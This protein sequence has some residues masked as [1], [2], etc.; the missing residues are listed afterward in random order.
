MKGIGRQLARS[1]WLACAIALAVGCGGGGGGG[2]SG[3]SGGGSSGGSSSSSSGAG[4]STIIVG[5]TVSG[6]QGTGLTLAD[7]G[8]DSLPIAVNGSFTFPTPVATG[9]SYS[10][11]VLVQPT[12]PAQSCSVADGAGIA[13]TS[14]VTTVVVTCAAT[15][16]NGM[17]T[18][19]QLGATDVAWDSHASQLV[20]AIGASATASANTIAVVNPATGALSKTVPTGANPT[21]VR[22]SDDGQFL[23]VGL[24]NESNIQRFASPAL[25]LDL[26]IPVGGDISLGPLHAAEIQ[27]APGAAHTIAVA[28]YRTNIEPPDSDVAVFDDAVARTGVGS[29]DLLQWGADATTLYSLT[30]EVDPS[31][32]SSYSVGPGG[33][34]RTGGGTSVFPSAYD[35]K[36]ASGHLFAGDGIVLDPATMN[37]TG[38]L[39]SSGPVVVDLAHNLIFLLHFDPIQNY[40]TLWAFDATNY[41]PVGLLPLPDAEFA[42][43]LNNVPQHMVRWGTDGLAY[44]NNGGALV[45]VNHVFSL[46]VPNFGGSGALLGASTGSTSYKIYDLPANDLAWSPQ[47]SLI[48][49]SLPSFASGRGNT[50][51]SFD[52]T[53]GTFGAGVF[54]GS[55]PGRISLSDDGTYLYTGLFGATSVV[56]LALPSLAA[57][58]QIALSTPQSGPLYPDNLWVAPAQPQT[59]AVLENGGRLTVYDSTTPRATSV[60]AFIDGAQWGADASTLYT[61][62]G[63]DTGFSVS[64]AN[65]TAGGVGPL[66]N[67]FSSFYELGLIGRSVHY[68]GGLL[69]ADDGSVMDPVSAT[70][71]AGFTGVVNGV[72][73]PDLALG[74]GFF[75]TG[76]PSVP[77]III[78]SVD[79][80]HG[81]TVSTF[82]LPDVTGL[83]LRVVRWGADGLAFLTDSG[84]FVVVHGAFVTTPAPANPCGAAVGTSLT[85]AGPTD[86]TFVSHIVSAPI[87]DVVVPATNGPLYVSIGGSTG[88]NV[89]CVASVDPTT[90]ALGA[91]AF[92]GSRPAV[93]AASDDA[94]KLY[95][96]LDAAETIQRFALPALSADATI[97][98]NFTAPFAQNQPQAG[99][100]EV[101]PGAPA[102]IA[103]AVKAATF[104]PSSLGLAIVDGTTP[105]GQTFDSFDQLKTNTLIWAGSGG[106]L[107]GTSF[108]GSP[109]LATFS[110]TSSGLTLASDLQNVW[111]PGG[112]SHLAGGLFYGDGGTVFDPVA[113]VVVG[114]FVPNGGSF[115][116]TVMTV[117]VALGRAYFAYI[118]PISSTLRVQVFDLTHFTLLRTAN[119]GPAAGRTTRIV[120]WGTDGLAI[121]TT[122]TPIYFATNS[123]PLALIQGTFVTS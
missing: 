40:S 120:R 20:I 123:G 24:Q 60:T 11:T 6:L 54:V 69:Y 34:A 114:T 49:V 37:V 92:A 122:N 46:P 85:T 93:L 23:Y 41:T 27:V 84:E 77:G 107:Y 115:V 18:A 71:K 59:F 12:N 83:P 74:L 2:G 110:V 25:T 101:A 99:D 113:G 47:R 39:V 65:V 1:L 86:P 33:L 72:M 112:R 70:V 7:N 91:G 97:P 108:E 116:T 29:G 61:Y 102:T 111:G 73:V 109:D 42:G 30:Y 21:V 43:Q 35:M 44:T 80:V 53:A 10:V 68:A 45:I 32:F 90:G 4:G 17:Y 19:Y 8:G 87:S 48:Y 81:N 56:R 51:A 9:A 88:A 79:L 62:F 96:G 118:E 28:R 100:I 3:S 5:G 50:I 67:S 98:L 55:E 26:T 15:S 106:P 31:G 117:D 38:S 13:G 76:D 94:S 95:V 82:S 14:N 119:L 75:V 22:F 63:F 105:R 103:I 64:T 57:S 58:E 104:E 78:K 16:G 89:N 121:A 52:P 36:F 66:T